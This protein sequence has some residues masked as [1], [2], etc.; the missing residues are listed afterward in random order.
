[1]GVVDRWVGG[2]MTWA[3]G[4]QTG[5]R[6]RCCCRH[7]RVPRSHDP[8]SGRD[9]RSGH[10]HAAPFR[11]P[12][13]AV[14]HRLHGDAAGAADDARRAARRGGHDGHP[15]PRGAARGRAARPVHAAAVGRDRGSH[16]DRRGAR[17]RPGDGSPSATRCGRG[18]SSSCCR[19][20]PARDV[21][22]A[23]ST[24]SGAADG[25]GPRPRSTRSPPP[26]RR[27][28]GSPAQLQ[29]GEIAAR[30]PDRGRRCR[31]TAR[32]RI[33][34]EGHDKVNFAIVAAG[35]NAASPHHH[36]GDRVI[37]AGEIVLCDFGGHDGRLLLRHHPLRVTGEAARR[38]RRGLRRAA[39]GAAGRRA[40]AAISARRA[41]R[42]TGRRAR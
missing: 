42:S 38:D 11:R 36:A 10:R 24:S 37:R 23:P 27:S 12:R 17:G 1:M 31:P 13:P 19:S 7:R 35:E 30:R 39:R 14:P 18:S 34:A 9:G 32:R 16:G 4:W 20:C 6:E 40:A 29:A 21:P 3:R 22:R 8:N 28:T 5:A 26:A 41:R 25:Q 15:A 33:V 2:G